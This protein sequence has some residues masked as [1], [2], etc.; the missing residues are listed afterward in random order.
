VSALVVVNPT[1]R[2]GE[3]G[4]AWPELEKTV[5]E[6]VGEKRVHVAFT[7]PVDHGSNLVRAALQSGVRKI[8]VVGGDGT[9]SEAIQ[10]FFDGDRTVTREAVLA[11]LPAGR[12]DDFFK[13]VCGDTKKSTAWENGLRLLAR[14]S[15][16][17]TDLGKVEFVSKTGT[18]AKR[19]FINVASFGYP[20]LVVKRVL[21]EEGIIGRSKLGK[22]S[23]AYLAQS[24]IALGS[25]KPVSTKIIID[26]EEVH[27][28]GIFS[29]FILNGRYNASGICW[30]NQA[31]VDDGF[32]H[33]S[34][35]K[36]RSILRSLADTR[37]MKSGN[38]EGVEGVS[39]HR[40][41]NIQVFLPENQTVSHPLCEVDG[42]IPE[43]ADT[44]RVS[45]SIIEGGL[46]LLR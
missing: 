13:S 43:P 39:L 25:Y 15:M 38:W 46:L 8:V 11:I 9:I 33:V 4:K 3:L 27:N 31:S 29:G 7:S 32:F 6:A 20:G 16:K 23:L 24:V 44:I 26:D 5:L 28:G 10:G 37:N 30:C 35:F 36:P 21:N 19:Y 2:A 1:A 18:T 41:K 34:I 14:G 12:G 17:R 40:G 45:F 22:G 42:D